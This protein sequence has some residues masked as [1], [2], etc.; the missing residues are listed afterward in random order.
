MRVYMEGFFSHIDI[1]AYFCVKN[2]FECDVGCTLA[3]LLVFLF[4]YYVL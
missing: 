3:V 2:W 1:V 4:C